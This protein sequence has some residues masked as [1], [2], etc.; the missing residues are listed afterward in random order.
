VVDPIEVITKYG[1]DAV[2]FTLASQA[3]PGTDIAFSEARTEGYR[4]FA[5]KIWNAARFLFMNVDRAAEA[6]V[7][8]DLSTL[9][10]SL[11]DGSDNY[12][13]SRWIRSQLSRT[14]ALVNTSLG[15]YRFDEAANHVYQFFWGDFCDWYLEVVKLRLEFVDRFDIPSRTEA[16]R[17]L[18]AVFEA[19]LRLLSPFMPFLTEEIWQAFYAGGAPAKSIALS[20]FPLAEDARYDEAAV[21]QMNFLKDLIVT[22]RGLRKDLSVPEK[23]FVPIRVYADSAFS[24]LVETNEDILHKLARINN[25]VLSTAPLTGEAVRSTSSFDVAVIYE[26]QIDAAAERERLNKD[27]AKYDKGLQAAEKQLNNPG[28]VEKAPAHIIDGLKKQAAET[29]ALKE[30]AEAA[31]AALPD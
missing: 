24:N 31:L 1:T 29:R 12:I 2:R 14:A 18:L 22:V 19:A 6:G 17:K 25:V 21:A 11:K 7:V 9:S 28:F 10:D 5:N 4:A 23:E 8:I 26:R 20:S 16:L 3:S 13:E 27:L 30:K 15:E